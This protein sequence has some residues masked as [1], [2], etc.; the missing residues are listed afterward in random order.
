M[1]QN[2]L[3]TFFEINE[4]HLKVISLNS[5][6]EKRFLDLKFFTAEQNR[7]SLLKIGEIDQ[8]IHYQFAEL[9]TFSKNQA[10][11]IK[12]SFENNIQ[13][14]GAGLKLYIDQTI[15]RS[16]KTINNLINDFINNA[17]QKYFDLKSFISSQT[18]ESIVHSNILSDIII[19]LNNNLFIYIKNQRH[20][21]EKYFN[22][23][24]NETFKK[25]EH[26]ANNLSNSTLS[27]IKKSEKNNYEY[28]LKLHKLNSEH[29]NL[30][31][32]VQHLMQKEFKDLHISLNQNFS[33][34]Q[35]QLESESYKLQR[36]IHKNTMHTNTLISK[37]FGML[38]SYIGTMH[39]DLSA[40]LYS[41]NQR[42]TERDE[43]ISLGFDVWTHVFYLDDTCNTYGLYML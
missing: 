5:M 11:E 2:F 21:R 38:T 32:T 12:L 34:L 7:G 37:K 22:Y 33:K 3:K 39:S 9:K 15:N 16:T 36:L 8:L 1:D 27:L 14:N 17:Q 23:L 26:L 19:Q 42:I 20:E 30:T 4:V 13:K 35:I 18:R 41:L 28:Y 25:I 31:H 29:F 43:K 10:T 40:E 6:S 24:S